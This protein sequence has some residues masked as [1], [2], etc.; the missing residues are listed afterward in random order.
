MLQRLLEML[1]H[2]G[3]KNYFLKLTIFIRFYEIKQNK[4]N[5]KI[6]FLY[7]FS[8]ILIL[9][10]SVLAAPANLTGVTTMVKDLLNTL[11]TIFVVI[12]WVVAGILYLTSAGSP[13]K[14]GTAKKA[15]VAAI[16]GTVVVALANMSAG[17]Y[18]II[19]NALTTGT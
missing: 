2:L 19:Q 13:E 1:L 8:A 10:I 16:I 9:P 15:L 5:K 12:G 6:L 3:L 4:M 11:A 17:I 18:T 7:L 14:T